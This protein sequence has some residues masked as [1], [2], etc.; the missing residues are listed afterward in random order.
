MQ[1]IEVAN[2]W[3]RNELRD[4]RALPRGG[5]GVIE[6]GACSVLIQLA[7]EIDQHGLASHGRPGEGGPDQERKRDS[8]EEGR[9]QDRGSQAGHQNFTVTTRRIHKAPTTI[10]TAP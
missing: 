8:D 9:P 3:A 7:I 2:Q 10:E 6:R 5:I 4:E 1:P